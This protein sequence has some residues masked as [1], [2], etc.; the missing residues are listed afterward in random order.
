MNC[1]PCEAGVNRVFVR[2]GNDPEPCISPMMHILDGEP[3]LLLTIAEWTNHIAPIQRPKLLREREV[4]S[5]HNR[6]T[7]IHIPSIYL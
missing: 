5:G 6:A 3:T 1:N 2:L 4:G 7:Y